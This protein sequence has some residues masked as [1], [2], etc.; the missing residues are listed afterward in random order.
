MYISCLARIH[1]NTYILLHFINSQILINN[2]KL[3]SLNIKIL[4]RI[5]SH[6]LNSK[7]R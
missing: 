4:C 3:K 6:N 1:K 2:S 7:I 5:Y